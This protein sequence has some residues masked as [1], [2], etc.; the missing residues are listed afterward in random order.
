[1]QKCFSNSLHA[2]YILSYYTFYE[3][4]IFH[5]NPTF[6]E[7]SE[8]SKFDRIESFSNVEKHKKARS[9]AMLIWDGA[10]YSSRFLKMYYNGMLLV[11][12]FIN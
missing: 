7:I 9:A 4:S 10:D 1:M 6:L 8:R 3:L 5:A 12:L 11:H 2:N